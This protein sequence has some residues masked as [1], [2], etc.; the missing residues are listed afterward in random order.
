MIKQRKR[1]NGE[2][3]QNINRTTMGPT[4]NIDSQ[5]Q[6]RREQSFSLKT[7]S[8]TCKGMCVGG[9]GRGRGGGGRGQSY[10]SEFIW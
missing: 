5:A 4:T 1:L 2:L 8:P 10:Q 3:K 7:E 9:G 6:S